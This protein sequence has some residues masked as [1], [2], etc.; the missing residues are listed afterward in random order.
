VQTGQAVGIVLVLLGLATLYLLRDPV[1]GLLV[2]VYEFIGIVLGFVL[3]LAGLAL[4][5][6]RGFWVARMRK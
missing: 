3:L 1:Y 5:F 4:T 6:G 2:F